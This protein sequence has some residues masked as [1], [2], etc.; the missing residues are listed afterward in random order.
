MPRRRSRVDPGFVRA[1]KEQS[2]LIFTRLSL[3][4][5][6]VAAWRSRARHIWAAIPVHKY[7]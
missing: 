1:A 3:K 2:G 4:L 6:F 7:V 5:P